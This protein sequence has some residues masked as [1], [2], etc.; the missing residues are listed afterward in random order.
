MLS[1]L[2]SPPDDASAD[3]SGEQQGQDAAAR[4]QNL[5]MQ[6]LEMAMGSELD[7]T[8]EAL[9]EL[10]AGL[11][12]SSGSFATTDDEQPQAENTVDPDEVKEDAERSE[13]Q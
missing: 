6:L 11:S 2:T 12:A 7:D 13:V 1:Q 5:L 4:A 8:S 10:T 9:S 3:R